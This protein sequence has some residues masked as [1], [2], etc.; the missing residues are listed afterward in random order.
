M[1]HYPPKIVV[2]LMS[3]FISVVFLW[4]HFLPRFPLFLYTRQPRSSRNLST[5]L[6]GFFSRASPEL[7]EF[8]N[9][10]PEVW[11]S[12]LIFQLLCCCIL[13]T[14]M[15]RVKWQCHCYA[16]NLKILQ[17]MLLVKYGAAVPTEALSLQFSRFRSCLTIFL[18]FLSKLQ[19]PVS[20]S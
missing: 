11:L 9:F 8:D 2:H 7:S 1:T 15:N 14:L 16:I 6:W 20:I 12:L 10:L 13:Q 18:H 17:G 5:V 19:D 3:V 4:L